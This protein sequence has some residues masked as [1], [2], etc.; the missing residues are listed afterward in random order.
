MFAL[1]RPRSH[2]AVGVGGP[3]NNYDPPVSFW[4][5]AEVGGLL[6]DSIDSLDQCEVSGF[7]SD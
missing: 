3:A 1:A 4:A 7:P 6:M 5:D 2:Y